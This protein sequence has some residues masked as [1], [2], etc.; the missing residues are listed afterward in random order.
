MMN[1]KFIT[2]NERKKCQKVADAFAEL[3]DQVDIIVQ[4]AGRYGFVKVYC[5]EPYR[6]FY[7]ITTFTNSRELFND[8]WEE[9]FHEQVFALTQ[10]TPHIDLD[11]H[12]IFKTLPKEKQTEIMSKKLYFKKICNFN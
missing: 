11:P 9:W 4:D 6:G 1:Q 10:G 8:L 12:N 5:Y 2:D 3:Y 7:R